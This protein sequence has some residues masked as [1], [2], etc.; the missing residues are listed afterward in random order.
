[1]EGRC[2][3]PKAARAGRPFCK[4]AATC[5]PWLLAR[6]LLLPLAT[7]HPTG[8]PL[9]SWALRAV[10]PAGVLPAPATPRTPRAD[11]C[12]RPLEG[13]QPSAGQARLMGTPL[14]NLYPAVQAGG[15]WPSARTH[16]LPPL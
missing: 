7:S 14:A 10:V 5:V 2:G 4:T 1:M 3:G 16:G 9:P 12:R 11:D 13:A 15:V 8:Q 6:L